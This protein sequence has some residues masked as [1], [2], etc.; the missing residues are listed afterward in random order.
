M[1]RARLGLT[2]EEFAKKVQVSRQ[3]IHAIETGKFLPSCMLA[4]KIAHV[5]KQR[6]EE[7]FFL[8]EEDWE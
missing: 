5:C 2:Q 3:T 1:E 7:I 8:E 4:L 6:V